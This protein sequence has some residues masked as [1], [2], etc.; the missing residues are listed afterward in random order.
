MQATA[1]DGEFAVCTTVPCFTPVCV[2]VSTGDP[3]AK[4]TWTGYKQLPA[5]AHN[6]M[7]YGNCDVVFWDQLVAVSG[8]SSQPRPTPRVHAGPCMHAWYPALLSYVVNGC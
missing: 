3:D 4:L 2:A 7:V 6:A 1:A 8:R 5:S